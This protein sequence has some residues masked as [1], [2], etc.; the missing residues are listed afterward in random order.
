MPPVVPVV[1]AATLVP[2]VG[3]VMARL[4]PPAAMAET[5]ALVVRAGLPE[6]VGRRRSVL[7]QTVETAGTAAM[8]VRPATALTAALATS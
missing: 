5:A 6:P 8:P 3:V 1:L 7:L 4:R 2:V